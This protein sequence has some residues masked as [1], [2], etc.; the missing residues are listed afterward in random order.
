MLTGVDVAENIRRLEE[1]IARACMRAGRSPQEVTIVAV[2]KTVP[3]EW[4]REAFRAGIRHFGEN[5]VQE[6]E[7]KLHQMADIRPQTIWHMVGHLQTNKV[8][9][10]LRIFDTVDSVDSVRLAVCLNERTCKRIPVLLQVNMAGEETKSGFDSGDVL[11][12][13]REI[14]AMSNLELRGLMTIAPLC[15]DAEAVRPVFRRLREL[16]DSLGLAELSMGMSED[17]EVAV[18]E[19]ATMVRI[20]RAIFGE[21]LA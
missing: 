13:A 14:A 15:R 3:V 1:R 9:R 20:G 12:A 7:R 2:T 8:V 17:Y 19:G 6:A 18:E 16:R 21:R 5:R 10:A 11:A 4:I